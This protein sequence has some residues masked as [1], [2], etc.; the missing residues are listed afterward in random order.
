MLERRN[1]QKAASGLSSARRMPGG[2]RRGH[3]AGFPRQADASVLALRPSPVT[4]TFDR[5]A[6]DPSSMA[7]LVLKVRAWIPTEARLPWEQPQSHTP[8]DSG[9]DA[10]RAARDEA[11]A[12]DS[13]LPS[14]DGY[15][16]K[17]QIGRGASATVY[18]ARELKHDRLVALKVLH[19]VLAASLQAERFLREISIVARLSHPNILPLLDSGRARDLL[20]YATPY[21]AGESLRALIARGPVPVKDAVRLAREVADA[22]DRAH[23]E[24]V[25]HRDVKPENILL[26]DGHALVADFGIARA[27]SLAADDRLTTL[28]VAIGT[29]HY[30][31]PEQASGVSTVDHRSDIY[32]L[33]CVMFEM[34]TGH[35]PYEG[36]VQDVLRQHISA[37]VPVIAGSRGSRQVRAVVLQALSKAPADRFESAAGLAAALAGERAPFRVRW[38]VFPGGSA[39]R[40]ILVTLGSVVLTIGMVRTASAPEPLPFGRKLLVGFGIARLNLDT[41][42][43]LVT[44]TDS[45]AITGDAVSRMQRALSQWR[46]IS[47]EPSPDVHPGDAV[48]D[49]EASR[50]IERMA[51][52]IGAGRV[53]RVGS[54]RIGDSVVIRATVHDTRRGDRLG[55]TNTATRTALAD[56]AVARMSDDLLFRAGI[57]LGRSSGAPGTNSLTAR[58][59]YFRAH[60]ALAGGNFAA[61]DSLFTEATF[62][63]P[64]YPQALAWLAALRSWTSEV[65]STWQALPSRALPRRAGISASDSILLDAMV[66]GARADLAR[67][68]AL[69]QELAARRSDDFAAWYGLGA[70]RSRDMMVVRDTS[71]RYGWRF[72]SSYHSAIVAYETAFRLRPALLL[73]YGGSAIAQ[74]RRLML[75]GA[76]QLVNGWSAGPDSALFRGWPI[77]QGD[78]LAIVPLSGRLVLEGP[79]DESLTA[80][81]QRQR[82]RFR[83]L[84]LLWRSEF[85][86]SPQAIEGHAV[87]LEMLGDESSLDT[88]RRA[89]SLARDPESRQRMAANEVVLRVKF[90]TPDNVAG[91]DSARALGDSLLAAYRPAVTTEPAAFGAVAALI[92]RS[93]AAAQYGRRLIGDERL[94]SLFRIGPALLAFASLGGPPDSIR[95]LEAEVRRA[96]ENLD[97]RARP[98][99]TREWLLRAG[100]LAFPEVR[101]RSMP[102]SGNVGL[103]SADMIAAAIRR[104]TVRLNAILAEIALNRS[105]WRPADVSL[106]ALLQEASALAHVGFH[107]RAIEWLDPTLQSLR[108][109]AQD[110]GLVTRTGPLVRAMALR[111]ELAALSGDTAAARRWARPVV[112][113]WRD[114]DPFLRP[115]IDRMRELSR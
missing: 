94:Q 39:A 47:V 93:T 112:V 78:T 115:R 51:L 32:S 30:M 71:W 53:V 105:G 49:A 56:T 85:P 41:T 48:D 101:T 68:C 15:E 44:G 46:E 66:A 113:L 29:P 18:L 36:P 27:V 109:S 21:V 96:I 52:A 57:P 82:V 108:F 84:T 20:Y 110:L 37:P 5:T 98:G 64:G 69:W 34:L 89:R 8:R 40:P 19:S 106:D 73:G 6:G 76:G 97:A 16:V 59:R 81:I 9:A 70:C 103:R 65:R 74:L 35:P 10:Q 83:D 100:A 61:A 24:G 31:S 104:D 22:L 43:Y 62:H 45:G 17:R 12:P 99:A 38:P 92:G 7:W 28:G 102:D 11:G 60:V 4:G 91:L 42:L 67:A 2:V 58:L 54:S 3:A 50:R 75:T 72:R 63:D 88:L 95:Q 79:S 26:A 1:A 90:A 87:A 14:I 86:L 55:S 114:A 33:G 107:Q 77:W 25:I 23:R 13:E 80:A 111:A